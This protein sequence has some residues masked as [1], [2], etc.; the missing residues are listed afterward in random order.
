MPTY[1]LGVYRMQAVAEKYVSCVPP[2]VWDTQ[3]MEWEDV[4][5][6]LPRADSLGVSVCVEAQEKALELLRHPWVR[7]LA[8]KRRVILGG[9]GV[10]DAPEIFLDACEDALLC[11]GYGEETYVKFLLNRP[12]S[13]IPNMV[14]RVGGENVCT[15]KHAPGEEYFVP[16][17]QETICRR[18]HQ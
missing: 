3:Y 12:L 4:L 14:Y 5:C 18:R 16:L 8:K 9:M 2:S 10:V 6:G 11:V 1:P 13:E 15:E 17:R 7:M